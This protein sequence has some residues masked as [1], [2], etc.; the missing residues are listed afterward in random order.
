LIVFLLIWVFA[1]VALGGRAIYSGILFRAIVLYYLFSAL[2]PAK[3][4]EDMKKTL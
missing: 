2:K 1:I 4:W 3:A